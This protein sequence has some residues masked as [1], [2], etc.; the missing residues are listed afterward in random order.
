MAGIITRPV[1]SLF[2][3]Q[4]DIIITTEELTDYTNATLATLGTFVSVGQV[5]EDTTDFSG[6]EATVDSIFDEQGNVITTAF[7]QG[8]IAFEFSMA[9]MSA[10]AVEFFLNGNSITSSP[11]TTGAPDYI[12]TLG[13]VVGFGH[14]SKPLTRSV[15]IINSAENK[16]LMI[17]KANVVSSLSFEGDL[18]VIHCTVTAENLQTGRLYTAMI[19]EGPIVR[20]SD[21]DVAS[22]F[23]V[24]ASIGALNSP[25]IEPTSSVTTKSS[26]N[27]TL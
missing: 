11:T 19:L 16:I 24:G 18:M 26:K 25:V 15:G 23:S 20:E 6:D 14:S 8:S 5:V 27:S 22:P 10:D 7:T 2:N 12:S 13:K 1:S 4:S 17:P 3:G 9:N 21:P